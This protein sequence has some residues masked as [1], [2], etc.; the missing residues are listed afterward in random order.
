VAGGAAGTTDAA[1][2]ISSETAASPFAA[3]VGGTALG[4]YTVSLTAAANPALAPGGQLDLG[5]IVNLSLLMG[6][7]FTPKA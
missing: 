6:Y 2:A 3:L 4:S 1:G 7:S 5:P